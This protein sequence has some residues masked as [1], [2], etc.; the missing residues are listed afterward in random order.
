[1]TMKKLTNELK[2]SELERRCDRIYSYVVRYGNCKN[3][4]IRCITCGR[5]IPVAK[6]HNC[7]YVGRACRPLRWDL[8]NMHPGCAHCNVYLGGNLSRYTLYMQRR[9][10]DATVRELIKIED[11]WKAGKI[12]PFRMEELRKIYSDGLR[13]LR[14]IEGKIGKRLVPESWVPID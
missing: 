12:K 14:P 8:R 7:H 2:R 13:L 10:G 1:M 9:Y 3:G 11:D 4:K 6:S 5:L